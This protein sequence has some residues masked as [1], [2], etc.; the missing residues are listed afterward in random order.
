MA[1]ST[2]S[3][4]GSPREDPEGWP[5]LGFQPSSLHAQCQKNSRSLLVINASAY[6]NTVVKSCLRFLISKLNN[7]S[8][9]N[10]SWQI[11]RPICSGKAKQSHL[12]GEGLLAPAQTLGFE[13]R[14]A[15]GSLL[16]VNSVA[17]SVGTHESPDA[18]APALG[19][20]LGWATF[21]FFLRSR[22]WWGMKMHP[23][24]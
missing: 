24:E 15:L 1:R 5:A 3:L 18:A 21:A 22:S 14:S 17:S 10:L 8:L 16:H 12:M 23:G 7:L 6:L 13:T 4:Q 9:C 20:A 19:R 2:S 11:L